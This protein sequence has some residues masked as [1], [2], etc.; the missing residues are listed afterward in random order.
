MRAQTH[1]TQRHRGT[2]MG[3]KQR[4]SGSE[5]IR[6][7]HRVWQAETLWRHVTTVT[8][9]TSGH[10]EAVMRDDVD[11]LKQLLD[12]PLGINEKKWNAARRIN[13]FSKRDIVVVCCCFPFLLVA[14][15]LLVGLLSWYGGHGLDS[16]QG[17]HFNSFLR[18]LPC[19]CVVFLVY[20]AEMAALCCAAKCTEF[21]CF[22]AGHVCI[23]KITTSATG[24]QASAQKRDF[25]HAYWFKFC[26]RIVS[27]QYFLRIRS[28]HSDKDIS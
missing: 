11:S 16:F 21:A 4:P 24:F 8:W 14:T 19:P 27:L 23:Y 10:V 17:L 5:S 12:E 18:L 3:K 7:D 13:S 1:K 20:V 15:G 28:K 6:V 2:E 9:A 25:F 26:C 22:W